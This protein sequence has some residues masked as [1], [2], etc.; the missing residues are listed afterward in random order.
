MPPKIA[1]V[2]PHPLFLDMGGAFGT[3]AE[4]WIKLL[5]DPELAF[6]ASRELP[7][8]VQNAMPKGFSNPQLKQRTEFMFLVFPI[9]KF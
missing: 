1:I 4:D 9:I 8:F 3:G 2:L 6:C 7:Q 5:C